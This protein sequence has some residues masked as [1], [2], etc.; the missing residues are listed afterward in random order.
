MY[1]L[2]TPICTITVF[3]FIY[4]VFELFVRREERKMLIDKMV[5]GEKID[6]GNFLSPYILRISTGLSQSIN[7]NNALRIGLV[8]LGIGCGLLC[9]FYINYNLPLQDYHDY[10]EIS[11]I[12]YTASICI[13]GGAA[14][15]IA[16]LMEHSH[17]QTDYKK[18]ME[19]MKEGMSEETKHSIEQPE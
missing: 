8:L 12:V 15:I 6:I 11:S 4:R 5:Q 2:V 1:W 3:W 16:Y 19:E 17:Q 7:R 10:H 9:G 18:M 13:F 14:F